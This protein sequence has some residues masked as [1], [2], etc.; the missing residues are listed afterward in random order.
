MKRPQI[1]SLA[2]RALP[3]RLALA[4]AV[5]AVALF[6]GAAPALAVTTQTFTRDGD[7]FRIGTPEG[8]IVTPD[9][10]LA[11]GPRPNVVHR[12]ATGVL[13]GLAASGDVALA[14]AGEK[15]GLHRID[16]SAAGKPVETIAGI[17]RGV[18]VFA[19]VRAP[20][21]RATF[22]AATGPQ[23]AVYEV[24][25]AKKTAKTL[26]TPEATYIWALVPLPGGDLAVA[27]GLPGKVFRVDAKGRATELWSTADP[28]V[29]A[30]ALDTDGTLLAGTAGTGQLVRLD[31]KGGAF[32]LFD[33]DRPET[34]ALAVDAGGTIWA[35]FAG[36]RGAKESGAPAAPRAAVQGGTIGITV[37]PRAAGATTE[38]AEPDAGGDEGGEGLVEEVVVGSSGSTAASSST[39]APPAAA[40]PAPGAGRAPTPPGTPAADD[41]EDD[42][43]AD[44]AKKPSVTAPPRTQDLPAGGGQLVRLGR[45]EEPEQVWSDDKETP[46]ALC[47]TAGGGVLLGTAN[48]AHVWSFD[49]R[50]RIGL[51]DERKETRAISA[52]TTDNGRVWAAT[53][54]PA[55]VVAYGPEPASPARWTSDVLDARVRA[56]LGRL[57]VVTDRASAASFKAFVR[58]GNASEPGPGWTGWTPVSGAVAPPDADG[59]AI[60][61]PLA[62]YFQVRVEAAGTPSFAAG[63][64]RIALHYRPVNRAPKVDGVEMLPQ[65]VAFRAMPPPQ[66]SSGDI[67]VVPPPRGPEIEKV[68]SEVSGTWR[69]KKAFEPGALT[70]DWDA[71]DPDS[72]KLR[73]DLAY[74]RDE[75]GPCRAWIALAADLDQ[76][77]YSFDGRVLPDGVYRFRVIASDAVDNSVGDGRTGELV[78]DPYPVDNSP[79]LVDRAEYRAKEGGRIELTVAARDPGARLVKAEISTEPGVYRVLPAQDG[80]GDAMQ[81]TWVAT[82]D[83]PRPGQELLVRVVDAAGN[84]TTRRAE[85]APAGT[86]ATPASGAS[87][88]AR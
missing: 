63:I 83:A 8:M 87:P 67:P 15:A 24:D 84:A 2:R 82:L 80:V 70:I 22:Y 4:A 7:L 34:A 50:G 60:A 1:R 47:A 76:T 32:V 46:M 51:F 30:L 33:S 72:D 43:G 12:P 79:P 56:T 54:N 53:S 81:E 68:I 16:A 52:L 62:R 48:V 21:G 61:V 29:R 14:A 35:A 85:P 11:P 10:R 17:D 77:F 64:G 6:T 18:E 27:T 55:S 19:V 38:P 20:A 41:D 13:W 36:A 5:V 74:C 28:H 66:M 75:G 39:P 78:S 71:K 59:G 26:F 25:A 73:Y 3:A 57:H 45:G 86:A 65:G 49:A 42:T 69:S 88:A 31:G 58:A 37:T 23:G 9:G 40:T 44:A